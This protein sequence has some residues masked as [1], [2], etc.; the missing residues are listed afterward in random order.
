MISG[1]HSLAKKAMSVIVAALAICASGDIGSLVV[2]AGETLTVTSSATYDTVTVNGTL[3]VSAGTLTAT[4]AFRIADG[5]GATGTLIVTNS[6]R[7][8]SSAGTLAVGV[9]GGSGLVTLCS[10]GN[11]CR[12]VELGEGG[13]ASTIR[14]V[15]DSGMQSRH[16]TKKGTGTCRLEFMGGEVTTTMQDSFYIEEGELTLASIDG[17]TISVICGSLT[18][19]DHK[20]L[21]SS[22]SGVM[23]TEGTGRF[24]FTM[25]SYPTTMQ[26]LVLDSSSRITWGHSGGFAFTG[27]SDMKFLKANSP[28]CFDVGGAPAAVHVEGGWLDVNGARV[29]VKDISGSGGVTNR[30]ASVGAVVLGSDGEDHSL[31]GA[32][33]WDLRTPLCKVGAG[34]LTYSGASFPGHVLV[35]NGLFRVSARHDV[36]YSHYRFVIDDCIGTAHDSMQ[37]SEF[38]LL[39]GGQNVTSLRS[40]YTF[41]EGADDREASNQQGPGRALDGTFNTK[42]LTIKTGKYNAE[43]MYKTNCWVQV[44]FASPRA[45]SDYDW[46]TANDW[47]YGQVGSLCRD[48]MKWRLLGSN[49]GETWTELDS[50]DIGRINLARSAWTGPYSAMGS[51]EIAVGAISVAG[52]VFEVLGNVASSSIDQ[53]GGQVRIGE[54]GCVRLV[55]GDWLNPSFTADSA[56]TVVSDSTGTNRMNAA[57]ADFPCKVSVSSGTL[58]FAR[59]LKEATSHRL[60]R[61]TIKKAYSATDCTQISRLTLFDAS[62]KILSAGLSAASAGTSPASLEAGKC[63]YAANYAQGGSSSVANL[64]DE[65]TSTKMCLTSLSMTDASDSSKWRVVHFRLSADAMA[66]AVA[67]RMTTANDNTPARNP[68]IWTLEGS[69]D[70]GATWELLDS[71]SLDE[72]V[73]PT[74][75]YTDYN[76]G[77]PFALRNAIMFDDIASVDVASM[78]ISSGASAWTRGTA[79]AS[80]ALE[81]DCAL[82]GGTLESLEPAEGGALYLLNVPANASF[83]PYDIPLAVGSVVNPGN[84][85]TWKVYVNGVQKRSMKVGASA[86]GL[87]VTRGGLCIIVF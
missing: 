48:P 36:V 78:A 76:G 79:I 20:L 34:T 55:N 64:F 23:T 2:P 41:G 16:V 83:H 18:T 17:A 33:K 24:A 39:L 10:V 7:I 4:N 62:G 75:T 53:T 58:A 26:S 28:T 3:I 44:D 22:G 63:A 27:A 68:V 80:H 8:A 13:G 46:G 71:R 65:N 42:W 35:S 57:S 70:G 47:G 29:S 5:E 32:W 12:F 21:N 31:N 38:R 37:L 45:I 49:D 66:P 85:D 72:F 14:Y 82:G 51:D 69:S 60:F 50:R 9:N 74:T 81:V 67:Y 6:A 84:L 52:G 59:K 87:R 30:A 1:T 56:G 54:T 73:N 77:V 86:N 11:S 15:S 61:F 43:E 25:E 40:G 19:G